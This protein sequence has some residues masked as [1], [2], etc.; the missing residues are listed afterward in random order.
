MPCLLIGGDVQYL[1]CPGHAVLVGYDGVQI[2]HSQETGNFGLS[3]CPAL[4]SMHGSLHFCSSGCSSF[5][6]SYSI[7]FDKYEICPVASFANEITKTASG[8][9]I[10]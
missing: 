6:P 4:G 5:A 2:P 10:V 8:S 7:H 1:L 3:L 9:L